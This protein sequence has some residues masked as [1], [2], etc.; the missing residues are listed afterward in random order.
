MKASPLRA[1][2][3]AIE[4]SA[5]DGIATVQLA[6]HQGLWDPKVADKCMVP[7]GKLNTLYA[8]AATQLATHPL[9]ERATAA[10]DRARS[11]YLTLWRLT[12]TYRGV[13]PLEEFEAEE[14]LHSDLQDA[15]EELRKYVD[16]PPAK[17]ETPRKYVTKEEAQ[18]KAEEQY[19]SLWTINNQTEWGRQLGCHRNTVTKLPAWSHAK[20]K[21]QSWKKVETRLSGVI[22][23]KIIEALHTSDASIL[24]SLSSEDRDKLDSMTDAD[25]AEI[26]ELL[27]EQARDAIS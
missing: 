7:A 12:V 18:R 21:R 25:R 3:Y 16:A 14:Q 13:W 6:A 4:H 15:L 1:Y 17:D 9:Q 11:V 8:A 22:D 27:S 10:M 5:K 20:R 26:I 19:E 24:G 2:L 23:P